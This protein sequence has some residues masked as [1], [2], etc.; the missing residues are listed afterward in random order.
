MNERKIENIPIND[1][2]P[3]IYQPRIKFDDKLLTELS[4]S[5]KNHGIIQP[6][7]LRK[8]GN[9]YEI[10]DGER[11]YK[12]A[13]KIGM[14]T[15][16]AIILDVN[17]KETLDIILTENMQ[18]QLFSPIEEANAYQQ[19]M[20]LNRYDIDEL[21]KKLNKEKNYIENKLK[22]LTLLP[23]IQEA[24]LNNKISE[25]HA[26]ALTKIKD[27]EKQRK[28]FKKIIVERIP[29][30]H[31]EEI[32]NN[33]K[34]EE[35]NIKEDIK[36]LEKKDKV[37]LNDLNRRNFLEIENKNKMEDEKMDNTQMNFNQY[38]N[39]LKEQERPEMGVIS[40]PEPILGNVVSEPKPNDFFPSLEEQP[41]N[42]DVPMN[43][44]QEV[45]APVE[46]PQFEVPAPVEAVQPVIEQPA[47]PTM[48]V[49]QMPEMASPIEMPQ[50]EV[51]TPV[52]AVQPAIEQPVM[53]TM[54]VPQM[55]EMA[56]PIE[57]PQ[58][59]VPTPVET[60]QPAI[61]QPVMPTMEVPQMSEMASPIE[62]PQF[63]VPTPVETVQPA[64]EQPVM[65]TMEV[66]QMPEMA[67]PIEMPQFE[68]P[69]PV[70]TI[71]PAIEQPVMPTM[72]VP[73][74]PEMASPIEMPQFE[75]PTPVETVQ[76]VIEQPMVDVMPA[77][78][79]IRNLMPLLENS[80]Y[81]I[82]LEES[83]NQ[84]EYQVTIKVQ[85]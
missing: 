29:V 22:L 19:M 79:M 24:L 43:N 9:S 39:L 15:V 48:E 67:S 10:I 28:L 73:Q 54:E 12:S 70:E 26:R 27:K 75:V 71:Q 2:I 23:D 30:K 74:M 20:L 55:P 18:K 80:G 66:P 11:R 85:K 5:I 78:N 50:F 57:M 68:V 35:K 31:L 53:P 44:V 49:P 76:P 46:M 21:S 14:E 40:Q 8:M 32:I 56:S 16:P 7:I 47:M 72:E 38:N 13:K 77:V 64:I 84:N 69:T 17:D 82:L 51:P 3:N 36:N 1:I 59:E 6:L 41:L 81:K 63:E 58:F 25:G 60:V 83:D 4:E 65:P 33:S 61:E 62:M 45:I 37:S 52:E 34:K 42:I